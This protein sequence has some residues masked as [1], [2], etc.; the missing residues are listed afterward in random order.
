MNLER[1][2]DWEYDA[3]CPQVQVCRDTGRLY[4][5]NN[6]LTIWKDGVVQFHR[7][8]PRGDEYRPFF[9]K[10]FGLDIRPASDVKGHKFRTEEGEKIPS[11][12][13][14]ALHAKLY[15]HRFGHVFNIANLT[16]LTP[17]A[18][19]CGAEP[20]VAR[21]RD[22][23]AEV[24]FYKKHEEDIALAKTYYLLDPTPRKTHRGRYDFYARD[25]YWADSS[26][27]IH[28]WFKSRTPVQTLLATGDED[29]A[30]IL[31][32][33]FQSQHATPAI[34]RKLLLTRNHKFLCYEAT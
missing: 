3:W 10:H 20:I 34:T 21:V 22:H 26:R 11:G 32:W 17:N 23:P 6:G 15:D 9:A 13:I 14:N 31:G 18:R 4:R 7:W 8:F 25:P 1:M 30:H 5:E 12:S 33:F 2:F 16:F 19:A 27:F 28:T 24:E 29:K